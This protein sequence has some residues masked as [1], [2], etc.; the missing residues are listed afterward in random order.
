MR[1]DEISSPETTPAKASTS[2]SN[3]D[4]LVECLTTVIG[5]KEEGSSLYVLRFQTREETKSFAER[6]T[7]ASI[8]YGRSLAE[9]R[10]VTFTTP[11][12]A[13]RL[14]LS[15][16]LVALP[17]ETSSHLSPFAA[18]APAVRALAASGLI[19]IPVSSDAVLA[20]AAAA[21]AAS[22]MDN[23]VTPI[24]FTGGAAVVTEHRFVCWH[25]KSV[26][27]IPVE[28]VGEGLS[29]RGWPC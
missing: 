15:G 12:P 17:H 22:G 29:A 24:R 18:N 5:V 19:Y 16:Q 4:C 20:S 26:M 21:A 2:A 10:A 14:L 25:C 23:A 6:F 9:Q 8:D 28:V 7:K 1:I 27:S 13:Q 11:Q 3:P